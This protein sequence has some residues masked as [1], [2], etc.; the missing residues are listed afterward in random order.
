MSVAGS[1]RP[2]VD[3]WAICPKDFPMRE[4]RVENWPSEG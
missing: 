1:V 3:M 4:V 2:W